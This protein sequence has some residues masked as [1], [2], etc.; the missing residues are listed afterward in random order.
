MCIRDRA[1]TAPSELDFIL[2]GDLLNQCAGSAYALRGL[3]PAYLGPVS[4]TH[5]LPKLKIVPT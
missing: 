2:S 1:G 3:S 5:L 4:Y